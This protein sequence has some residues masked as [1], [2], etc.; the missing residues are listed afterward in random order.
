MPRASD[1]RGRIIFAETFRVLRPAV[2]RAREYGLERE[3]REG[4]RAARLWPWR[5]I[6]D[7]AWVALDELDLLDNVDGELTLRAWG[8][9]R[10]DRP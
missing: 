4:Y 2:R 9:E 3:F 10:E 6:E 7:A 8:G 5:N 1:G